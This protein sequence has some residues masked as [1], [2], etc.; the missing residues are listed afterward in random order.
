MLALGSPSGTRIINAIAQTLVNAIDHRMC[1]QAA[2]ELP[3]I[4]WSG[5]EFEAESD[6]PTETLEALRGMGHTLELRN[7]RSPW[8]GAV[9]AVAWEP[10][11]GIAHGAAD[12]RRQGAVAGA[13]LT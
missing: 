6:I 8:F 9:Q 7:A 4:H 2:V 10:E 3:R 12:P 1:L 11:L 13:A 5:D